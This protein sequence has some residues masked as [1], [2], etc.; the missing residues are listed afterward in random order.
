[1]RTSR[2]GQP[3]GKLAFEFLVLTA[4]RS[5]EVR[6]ATWAE[7]NTADRVWTISA[8]RMK[9]KR[10]HRVPLCSR[11]VEIVHAA[12]TLGDGKPLVFPMRSGRPISASTPGRR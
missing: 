7:I 9:A 3:A 5:A 11:A 4:A 12:R 6:L 8:L 2:A 1:M 10:E